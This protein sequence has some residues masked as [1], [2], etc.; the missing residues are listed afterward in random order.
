MHPAGEMTEAKRSRVERNID[1]PRATTRVGP[2]REK[3][4]STPRKGGARER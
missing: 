1:R 2:E 4:G 3:S